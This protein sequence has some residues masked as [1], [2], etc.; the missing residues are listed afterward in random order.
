MPRKSFRVIFSLN[1]Q[2]TA[3]QSSWDESDLHCIK[4]TNTRFTIFL[5]SQRRLDDVHVH[6]GDMTGCSNRQN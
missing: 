1:Q 6:V 3:R 2:D 5:V 4:E